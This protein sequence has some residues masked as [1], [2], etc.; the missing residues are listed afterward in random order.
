M[1]Q[2]WLD[3]PVEA[4]GSGLPTTGG[5]MTGTIDMSSGSITFS[6]EGDLGQQDGGQARPDTNSPTN[7]WVLSL[8]VAGGPT[9]E[10][11][12]QIQALGNTNAPGLGAGL[13]LANT[14]G[15]WGGID[16]SSNPILILD[17]G[18]QT[19]SSPPSYIDPNSDQI[20]QNPPQGAPFFI[21]GGLVV[22][23]TFGVNNS[24][25]ATSAGAAAHK[26]EIF[27]ASKNSL[28]FVYT[29]AS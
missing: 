6:G 16:S 28:G 7:A 21:S 20:T 19:V 23:N 4:G 17:T 14:V 2:G 25:S 26:F 1:A 15:M 11:D 10:F 29:Y 5:T 13:I 12:G 22:V 18:P 8:L 24:Q 9:A 27:D 3:L